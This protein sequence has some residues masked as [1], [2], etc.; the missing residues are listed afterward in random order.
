MAVTLQGLVTTAPVGFVF[1][2][3]IFLLC[4]KALFLVE[5]FLVIV[6]VNCL[7][8]ESIGPLYFAGG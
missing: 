1:E 8:C 7:A 3:S 4:Q 6:P 2:F 5:H